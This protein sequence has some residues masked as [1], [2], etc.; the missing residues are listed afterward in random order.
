MAWR[1]DIWS[2]DDSKFFGFPWVTDSGIA[3]EFNST[4]SIWSLKD[5]EFF[6]FP[7]IQKSGIADE[8]NSTKTKSC[9]MKHKGRYL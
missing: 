3:D 2:Q 5:G 8:F 6:G 1:A 7:F 9:L 4:N